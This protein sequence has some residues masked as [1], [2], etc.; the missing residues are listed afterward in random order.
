M[1]IIGDSAE[2]RK[3]R[4][5]FFTPPAVT[6]FVAEWAV[7]SEDDRV[8]E[9]SA[10]DGAFVGAAVQRL[11]VL[12]G[13]QPVVAHELHEA[14]AADTASLL[15]ELDYPGDVRVGDFLVTTAVPQFDAVIGNPPYVR[16]QGFTGEARAAGLAAARAQGVA[17]SN[18]ASSWAPFVIHASAYLRPGGRLGLVLPAELLSSNYAREVRDYLLARFGEVKIVMIERHVFPGVQTEALLLL[19]EG[20]GGTREVQFASLD[21][22]ASLHSVRFDST[23]T[24]EPGERWTSALVSAEAVGHL[25][26]LAERGLVGPLGDWGRL[27]L[28]AVTGN[29]RFF[30]L[31]PA[32]AKAHGL[33]RADLVPISPAGS[34]HLRALDFTK[35]DHAKIGAAGVKTLL[36][37]PERPS[38]GG[39]AFIALGEKMGVHTAY[40]CRVRTP[41]W[42]TPLPTAPDVLFT[43]MN[44][45]TPQLAANPDRLHYLNSVHGLYLD[46]GVRD[47]ADV[48]PLAALST[49]TGFSAEITGRA[50]GGGILKMEPREA[51]RLQVA[52][53]ALVRTQ[54][55]ALRELLP[56]AKRL[57]VCGELDTVRGLVDNALFSE[58]T[59]GRDE[60]AHI[61]EAQETLTN[62]RRTRASSRSSR[63]AA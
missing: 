11:R 19:A 18:L 26:G 53:P 40:K 3:A 32:E 46:E 35:K 27:S 22:A 44:E 4:G 14:S 58:R 6:A 24:V 59:M 2:S 23:L 20:A 21:D 25:R 37:R 36:F 10:G 47:L 34:S 54:V 5:A 39:E 50:Y 45:A 41:W 13:H 7:R 30:T 56:V 62:R 57:L 60:L 51:A 8:L 17:L 12:G 31:S 61:R 63:G 52:T 28:G 16:Y 43:Y 15:G 38:A 9:P 48:L 1:E 49:P 29:N 33:R 42:R 55:D